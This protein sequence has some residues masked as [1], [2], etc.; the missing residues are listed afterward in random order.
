MMCQGEASLHLPLTNK[1]SGGGGYRSGGEQWFAGPFIQDDWLSDVWSPEI[2]VL[3]ERSEGFN[4]AFELQTYLAPQANQR[5]MHVLFFCCCYLIR[6]PAPAP[7]NKTDMC[8]HC[9]CVRLDSQTS[10]KVT[11]KSTSLANGLAFLC[12]SFLPFFPPSLP[13]PSTLSR[14]AEDRSQRETSG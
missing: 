2:F 3:L 11:V 14:G 1:F 9:V 5:Q 7:S 6:R 8:E 4:W 12:P 10:F 13:P